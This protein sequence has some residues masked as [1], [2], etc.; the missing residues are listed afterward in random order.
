MRINRNKILAFFGTG[1]LAT[2]ASLLIGLEDAQDTPYKDGVGITTVCVGSTANGP[3]KAPIDKSKVYTAKECAD[4]LRADLTPTY[5]A[6][7]KL[8]KIPV[9][10]LETAAYTSLTFNIGITAFSNS[11]LL[12]LL[13]SGDRV[14]A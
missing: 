13:N 10:D 11:T 12:K 7:R 2:V 4:R 6:V 5:D 14:R 1:V 9:S 3:A 8:V